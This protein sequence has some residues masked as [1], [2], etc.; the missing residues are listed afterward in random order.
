MRTGLMLV[1]ILLGLAGTQALARN[2]VLPATTS[3]SGLSFP[4]VAWP[5]P[6]IYGGLGLNGG[7]CA[8]MSGKVGTG[9]RIDQNH[10]ISATVSRFVREIYD[11]VPILRAYACRS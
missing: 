9:L 8:P 7:S 2:A 5:R 6:F 3:D 1:I 11:D 4:K 10:L